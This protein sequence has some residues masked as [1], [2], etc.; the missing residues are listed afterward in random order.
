MIG[1]GTDEVEQCT[2]EEIQQAK[3]ESNSYNP[4][5]EQIKKTLLIVLKSYSMQSSYWEKAKADFRDNPQDWVTCTWTDTGTKGG[6][7]CV[8]TQRS[9]ELYLTL[10]Q[11]KESAAASHR[12]RLD[13][14]DLDKFARNIGQIHPERAKCPSLS[15]R[16]RFPSR[17][18]T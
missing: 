13:L 7:G 8:E 10:P 2:E 15:P 4:K 6:G 12:S 18:V 11:P 3:R 5:M 1:R 17:N 9:G 16:Y 14:K